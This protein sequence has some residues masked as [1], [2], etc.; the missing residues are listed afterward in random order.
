[1]FCHKKGLGLT[2]VSHSSLSLLFLPPTLWLSR[3]T[4]PLSVGIL[5]CGKGQGQGTPLESPETLKLVWRPH[6]YLKAPWYMGLQNRDSCSDRIAASLITEASRQ[7]GLGHRK[8]IFRWRPI[9]TWSKWW[10]ISQ[11][12]KHENTRVWCKH[13]FMRSRGWMPFLGS[14]IKCPTCPRY[15]YGRSHRIQSS[16]VWWHRSEKKK[17]IVSL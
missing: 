16:E 3:W 8:H 10:Y 7:L 12:V 15:S 1:M 2:L 11:S 13:V 17:N 14:T 4:R 6:S 5:Q 9:T